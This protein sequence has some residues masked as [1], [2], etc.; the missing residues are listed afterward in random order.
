VDDSDEEI[1]NSPSS[2]RIEN[3]EDEDFDEENEFVESDTRMTN[4]R[5]TNKSNSTLAK[6][7]NKLK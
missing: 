4:L 7:I 3:Q 2:A 6:K 1:Q 5:I